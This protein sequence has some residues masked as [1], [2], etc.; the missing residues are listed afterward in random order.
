LRKAVFVVVPTVV[1]C[2]ALGW[3]THV[4]L[5]RVEPAGDIVI[6]YTAYAFPKYDIF[7]GEQ[8]RLWA[9]TKSGVVTKYEP[10]AGTGYHSKILTEIAGGTVQDV[11]FVQDVPGL[12]KRGALLDLAAFVAEEPDYWA[13]IYPA[14]MDFHRYGD[15]LY[16]LPGNLNTTVLYYNADLFD[17]EGLDYPDDTWTW[18]TLL[19]VAQ[20]LTKRD[21]TG[22]TTQF[23][24][25]IP[26][27]WLMFIKQNGGEM[28]SGSEDRPQFAL[29]SPQ[30]A[31]AMNWLRA[32]SEEHH[33]CPNLAEAQTQQYYDMFLGGNAGMFVGGRWY[34]AI[35]VEAPELN[36]RV[37]PLPKRLSRANPI[38][39]NTLGVSAQAQHPRLAFELA[40]WLT[41]TDG[42][43][44]LVDVGDSIPI[45]WTPEA[46]G[47]FLQEPGR[48]PG[49]NHVYLDMMEDGYTIRDFFH[50]RIPYAE[51]RDELL[52]P[53]FDEFA[54]GRTSAEETLANIKRDIARRLAR[55]G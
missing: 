1:A 3:A 25:A 44:F 52:K 55:P 31:E 42:I 28:W 22:K 10:I 48:P 15:A 36:W 14:L 18:D 13:S 12:A 50:P 45:R 5:V 19:E 17:A 46:N 9:E 11:F 16:G 37:A 20:A 34:T 6:R 27:D 49:E 32:L 40:K 33:V 47:H 2:V 21:A 39:F 35:F 4:R 23:G 26:N 8:G 7:R 41:R 54:I 30:A 43:T 51:L 29:D 24:A 53:R 38:G